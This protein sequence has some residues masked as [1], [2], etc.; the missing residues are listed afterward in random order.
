MTSDFYWDEALSGKTPVKVVSETEDVL[1]FH[2]TKPFWPVH[3]VV[4][5]KVHVPSLTDLGD[6]SIEVVH[7]VLEVV[8]EVA[9]GRIGR[10]EISSLT[11]CHLLEVRSVWV[12]REKVGNGFR[13]PSGA[14]T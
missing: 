4:V 6:H 7:R 1:A 14:S 9:I 10:I 13:S 11:L 8:R 3:I 12:D 5:P 2:H